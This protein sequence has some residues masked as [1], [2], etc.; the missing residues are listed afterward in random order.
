MGSCRSASDGQSEPRG[1]RPGGLTAFSRAAVTAFL[2]T[3]SCQHECAKTIHKLRGQAIMLNEKSHVD[4]AVQRV[5]K[6]IGIKVPPQ[7]AAFDAPAKSRV[8]FSTAGPQEALAESFDQ[9]FVALARCQDGRYD[10]ATPAAK[11]LYQLAHLLAHIGID[12]SGIRKAQ[13]PRGAAGECVRN[14]CA[15]VRPPAIH[16]GLSD[17][18]ASRDLFNLEVRK[19]ALPKDFERTAQDGLPG[20]LAAGAARRALTIFAVFC[21]Q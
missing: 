4:G 12:R 13:L 2:G 9:I 10:A 20:L 1:E 3:N 14:Q 19:T 11:Y 17:R 15:L 7:L 18:G 8:R 16:G 21:G 5:K 6:Q